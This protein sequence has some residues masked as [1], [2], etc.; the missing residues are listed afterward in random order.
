VQLSRVAIKGEAVPDAAATVVAI[1]TFHKNVLGHQFA[2]IFDSSQVVD[3]ALRPRCKS[4]LE[5]SP[6]IDDTV[7]TT[8]V[9]LNNF[10]SM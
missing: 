9:A 3:Q 6:V 1:F 7:T 10:R 8:P 4:A 2:R 5:C